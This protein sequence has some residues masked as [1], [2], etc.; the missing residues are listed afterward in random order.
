MTVLLPR[1]RFLGGLALGGLSVG[2]GGAMLAGCD[3]ISDAPLTRRILGV[4]QSLDYALQKRVFGPDDLAPEYRPDQM[5]P[6]FRTNGNTMP[7]SQTYKDMLDG[8]FRDWRLSVRGLVSRPLD[9]SLAAIRAMP[10]RTQIT[11]HACVE[12]WSAIG[13]WTGVQLR[14]LLEKAGL[15]PVT[16]YV[17]FHCA[18]DVEGTPFY[19]SVDV[20]EA[21]HPQTILAWRMNGEALSVGHGA[22]LRLR[23]ERQVGYKHAKYV[24]SVEAVASLSPIGKGKGGSWEDSDGYQWF[25]GI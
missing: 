2:A 8:G 15:L 13:Q 21:I 22:P 25:A 5:S 14:L 17:V 23:V 9:L 24:M 12:G 7:T 18:D 19:E 20:A 10:V 11:Q 1:R 16:R 6:V 3:R 4:G